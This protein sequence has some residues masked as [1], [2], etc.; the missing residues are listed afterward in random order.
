MRA[1]ELYDN[2]KELFKNH[3]ELNGEYFAVI[4]KTGRYK[5]DFPVVRVK[6]EDLDNKRKETEKVAELA[7]SLVSFEGRNGYAPK[8]NF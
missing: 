5:E 8:M 6:K 1:K 4:P 2:G 3:F 7:H